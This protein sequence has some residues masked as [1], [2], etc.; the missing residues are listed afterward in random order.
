MLHACKKRLRTGTWE[1][2]YL[3]EGQRNSHKLDI[4]CMKGR[5]HRAKLKV[6]YRRIFG[7]KQKRN[8]RTFLTARPEVL[9]LEWKK[10]P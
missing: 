6:Q 3:F 10:E 4:R 1:T 5:N 2:P 9:A 8:N 7:F